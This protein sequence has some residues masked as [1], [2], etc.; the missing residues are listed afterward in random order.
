MDFNFT[1]NTSKVIPIE[2]I[3]MRNK[4]KERFQE[5]PK[6]SSNLIHGSTIE[7]RDA[8]VIVSSSHHALFFLLQDMNDQSD[9]H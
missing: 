6:S 3:E 1:N 4:F 9:F 2:Y 8:T 5:I 7:I